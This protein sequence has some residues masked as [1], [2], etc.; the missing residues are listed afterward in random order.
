MF[1]NFNLYVTLFG[2]QHPRFQC[3]CKMAMAAGALL[4][5][6]F[7]FLIFISNTRFNALR[8]T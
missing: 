5:V 6:G 7:I 4:W 2:F 8:A 3:D 1:L